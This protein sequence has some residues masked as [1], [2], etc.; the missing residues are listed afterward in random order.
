MGKSVNINVLNLADAKTQLENE[1]ATLDDLLSRVKKLSFSADAKSTGASASQM[2]NL[3][4]VQMQNMTV[5]LKELVVRTSA[6]LDD[7]KEKYEFMD[8]TIAEELKSK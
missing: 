6:L 7:A 1:A 2:K 4:R 5:A 3:T 8:K